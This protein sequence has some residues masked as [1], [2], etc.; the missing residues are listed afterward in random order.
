M[1]QA[2]EVEEADRAV[3][4]DRG[5]NL[6][7]ARERDVVHLL[8][9][10]DQLRLCLPGL[11]VPDGAGGIDG[12]GADDGGVRLV[13]VERRQRRTELTVLVIVEELAHLDGGGRGPAL[14][15][16]PNPQ[17]I[18]RRR[19]QVR[20]VSHLVWNPHDLGCRVRVV[21]HCRFLKRS[22]CLIQLQHLHF[23]AVFLD[24]ASD[25]KAKFLVWPDAPAHAIELPWCI[26]GEDFFLCFSHGC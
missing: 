10:R 7:A 9:V 8:V 18:S 15:H 16:L 6:S 12:G 3:G 24:K 19:K 26:V 17:I 2:A 14:L 21:E 11:D 4:A 25:R 22:F 20:P 1:L 5:E 23:V 13:P